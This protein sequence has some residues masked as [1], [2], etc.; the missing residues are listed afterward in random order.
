MTR[1]FPTV[2]TRDDSGVLVVLHVS[3]ILIL[4][5]THQTRGATYNRSIGAIL[6]FATGT[7]ARKEV[8]VLAT[9]VYHGSLESTSGYLRHAGMT[10][11]R[12]IWLRIVDWR[13]VLHREGIVGKFNDTD[14]VEASPN[15]ILLVEFLYITRVDT[16]LHANLGASEKLSV[17]GKLGGRVAYSYSD[18]RSR[19]VAPKRGSIV[20]DVFAI[21][22]ID[23]RRP[24]TVAVL[25]SIG[26]DTVVPSGTRNDARHICPV[27]EV[28]TLLAFASS[29]IGIEGAVECSL[30]CR[31]RE[32]GTVNRVGKLLLCRYLKSHKS[33]KQSGK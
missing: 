23:I 8:V 14:V 27:H 13:E 5:R 11:P 1:S 33:K 21:N 19:A 28:G 18:A 15:E 25:C 12:A 30:N 32:I 7:H 22:I 31:V 17:V 24:K 29:C 10:R 9:L 4:I 26:M 6:S 20:A 2:I 16:V 3:A